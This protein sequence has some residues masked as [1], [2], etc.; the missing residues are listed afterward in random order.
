M[1]RLIT[2]TIYTVFLFGATSIFY[3]SVCAKSVYEWQNIAVS[4][5]GCFPPSCAEGKFPMAILPLVAFDDKLYSI[6]DK[7][8]WTSAD[9]INWNSQ[10]KTNW[11]ERHGMQFA[12]FRNKVWML[13]GM[14]TWDDFR[15]DV[16]SSADGK[17]WKQVVSKAE[18]SARRWHGVV[19]FKDKLWI[20]GGASSSG[21]PNQ[22]PTEFLSDVWS[23]ADGVNWTLVAANAPWSAKDGH[24]S[25]VFDDKIW[26]IGGKRDVWSSTDGKSW[27]PVTDK[28]EWSERYGSGGLVFDGKMWIFG[29]REKNDVWYSSNGK[30]WQKAFANAPW[31]TRSANYSVVFKNKIWLYSGKTGREDSFAGDIW[32]MSKKTE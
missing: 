8:V 3:S 5:K 6:G 19:V 21:R 25:L 27:T 7:R 9:G 13:G 11:G 4:G 10:P 22:T 12:F 14:K 20:L 32:A 26:I 2:S 18:W 15:N 30:N 23:S 28:A 24:T 31:S 29:G 16:W 1:K 17:E